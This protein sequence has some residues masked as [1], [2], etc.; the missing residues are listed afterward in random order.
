MPAQRAVMITGT[1]TG[2]GE[3]CALLSVLVARLL[4]D[5]ALDSLVLR[6]LGLPGR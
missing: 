4:P 6:H 3:A 2:S 5:R 1:L